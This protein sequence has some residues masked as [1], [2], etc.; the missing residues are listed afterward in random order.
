[1]DRTSAPC[2]IDFDVCVTRRQNGVLQFELSVDG[3]VKLVAI[4]KA[5]IEMSAGFISKSAVG[6]MR[7]KFNNI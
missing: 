2:V 7:L 5:E 3:S 6:V 1:M 4:S